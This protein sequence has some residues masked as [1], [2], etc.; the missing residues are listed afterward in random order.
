MLPG[1]RLVRTFEDFGDSDGVGRLAWSPD[2]TALAIPLEDGTLHIWDVMSATETLSVQ[3]HEDGAWAATFHPSGSPVATCGE[4]EDV[5]YWDPQSGRRLLSASS[6]IGNGLA[7]DATGERLIIAHDDG[8]RIWDAATLELIKTFPPDEPRRNIMDV[9]VDHTG[10]HM[11]GTGERGLTVRRIDD[12]EPIAFYES[13]DHI[14]DAAAF[15][16]RGKFIVGGSSAGLLS[17]WDLASRRHVVDLEGHTRSVVSVTFL[18]HG[19]LLVS[20]GIDLQVRLW[21]AD[22]WASVGVVDS[23]RPGDYLHWGAGLAAHPSRPWLAVP[24]LMDAPDGR[25][26]WSVEVWEFATDVIESGSQQSNV[27]YTSAKIVLV[28]ESGAGK[29]GLGWRLAHGDFQE[30]ASTHGQQFWVLDELS[31]TRDDGA[32]CEAILWDLAGQPDYRLIHA[33]FLDDADLG[34]VV[35]DPTR[36]DDPLGNV[37]YWLRQLAAA[38]GKPTR[39]ILVAARTDRGSPRITAEELDE[40]CR[41][42]NVDAYVSTSA[43]TGAGLD[44]LLQRIRSSVDWRAR[45]TTITTSTFKSIKDFVLTLKEDADADRLVLT[46]PELRSKLSDW[47]PD[48]EFTDAEMTSAVGH[49][50]KH[51]YVTTLTTS[52]GEAR[53]LLAP[54][55][56]NNLAASIVLEARRNEKGL[57]ALEERRLLA[58]DYRF[59]EL[60][61]LPK[62]DREVLIDSAISIFL[63]HNVCFRETDPLGLRVYLVFPELINLRKPAGEDPQVFEEGAAYTVQGAVTNVYASLV[64]LLGYTNTFTRTNQWRGQAQYVIGDGQVCGFSL[65]GDREAEL[66]F[67]LYFGAG[68]S[69]ST[70]VLFQAL[71]ESFLARRDLV[72][73]RF[74]PV[75]CGNGHRLNRA[76]V[77]EQVDQGVTAGFCT[78]CGQAVSFPVAATRMQLPD[79]QQDDLRLQGKIADKRSDFERSLFR[80]KAFVTQEGV[81]AP[82]CFI[83]YAWGDSDSER[84]VEH[85]LAADLAKAGVKVVLDRWENARVGASVSRFVE[86]VASS[87]KVIVVG[88]PDYRVKYENREPMRGFVVAAETDLIGTRMLGTEPDKLD[89]LPVLLSGDDRS[90]FPPLLNGR[91]YADFRQ[92]EAYFETLL[93]LALDIFAIEITSPVYREVLT[94]TDPKDRPRAI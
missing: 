13:N 47:R 17:V 69:P 33:M 85:N 3:A 46:L 6:D 44:E 11:L 23:L 92:A 65:E 90:S 31:E 2:G 43:F 14:F 48:W 70:R 61:D 12:G 25:L 18:E 16:P 89:V 38:G 88:T 42:W 93:R 64:V 39:T 15:D 72:V 34:L 30:H 81:E 60:G 20:L 32:Q 52:S 37:E 53:I 91:V 22:T 76:A 58:M 67:V 41:R 77:R 21:R 94:M 35:F 80:L 24:R 71:F 55:L 19:R 49:L 82:D 68:T 36:Q 27:A 73:H 86:R 66:S 51:G 1:V 50:A 63:A 75:V 87:T 29:T 56:L 78:R 84:W 40:F 59:P 8:L 4:D 9:S 83:S 26:R 57:G 5:S 74:D 45:P 54:E 79:A 62:D 10:R 7:F 28:G